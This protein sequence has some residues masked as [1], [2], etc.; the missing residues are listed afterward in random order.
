M[1]N[2]PG[3]C[4]CTAEIGIDHMVPYEY[5]GC[6]FE[7]DIFILEFSD[8]PILTVD[9]CGVTLGRALDAAAVYGQ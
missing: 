9:V 1:I 2:C 5:T 3:N 6:L 7:K 4:H 8:A